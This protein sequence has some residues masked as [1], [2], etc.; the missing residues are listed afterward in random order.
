MQYL[1]AFSLPPKVF[2]NIGYTF[3]GKLFSLRAISHFYASNREGWQ[4]SKKR[5]QLWVAGA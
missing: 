5:L 3:D 2:L 1:S 4:T